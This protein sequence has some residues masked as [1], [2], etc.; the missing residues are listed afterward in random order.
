MKEYLKNHGDEKDLQLRQIELFVIPLGSILNSDLQDKTKGLHAFIDVIGDAPDNVKNTELIKTF[1][2]HF[3]YK[4]LKKI[5]I[6][7]F[8][9]Y[10]CYFIGAVVYFSYPMVYKDHQ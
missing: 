3:Y 9:P 8:L 1:V 4:Y 5:K 10:T 6:Y 7:C 2:D